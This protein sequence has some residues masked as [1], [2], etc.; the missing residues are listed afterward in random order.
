MKVEVRGN[1]S[2]DEH[3]GVYVLM[4]RDQSIVTVRPERGVPLDGYLGCEV[5]LSATVFE[6]TVREPKD[7]RLSGDHGSDKWDDD[8]R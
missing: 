2:F 1:L 7:L 3:E 8:I 4:C 5:T 6:V